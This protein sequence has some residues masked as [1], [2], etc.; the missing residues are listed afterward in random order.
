MPAILH[1]HEHFDGTGY[2][3]GL[4]G[5]NIPLEARILAV[6]DAYDAMT[7]LRPYRE[8]LLPKAA[9]AELRCCAGTQ[10][11]PEL[12]EVFYKLMEPALSKE[13]EIK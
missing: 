2:P 4:Q 3:S 13:L 7:S 10:F 11:D 6:A 8:R 9:L 12:V 5:D 1:H